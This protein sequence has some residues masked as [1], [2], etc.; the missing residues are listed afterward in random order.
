M[1][2]IITRTTPAPVLNPHV[3]L[4]TFC[5]LYDMMERINKL[6]A[7]FVERIKAQNGESK[8]SEWQDERNSRPFPY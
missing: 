7:E 1:T 8:I 5:E 4:M 6:R 2:V 3:Y